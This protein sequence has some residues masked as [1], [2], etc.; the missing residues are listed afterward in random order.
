MHHHRDHEGAQKLYVLIKDVKICMMTTI[1]PDGTLHSRPMYNQEADEA[2]ELWFFTYLRSPKM[3]EVSKDNHVNLAYA[4]PDKQH[5]ISVSGR[6]EIIL[7]KQKI[8]EKWTEGLRTWFPKGPDDP[9]AA[10]I[11][12]HPERGEYW[13]SPSSTMLHL[14]GYVKASVTGEPPKEMTEQKKVDLGG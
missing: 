4:D 8:Q 7:D 10:L 14:Y 11:R 12:V 1:E 9:Q 13:D 3:T 2:G 5:Y 6:A